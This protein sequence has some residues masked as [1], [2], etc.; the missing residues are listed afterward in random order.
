MSYN[1]IQLRGDFERYEG[2]VAA[3]KTITPGMLVEVSATGVAPVGS[4]KVVEKAFAVEDA[5]QGKPIFSAAE[6]A[7]REASHGTKEVSGDYAAGDLIQYNIQQPGNR[8]YAWVV[9]T[10]TE[11]LAVGQLLGPSTT[12]GVLGKNDTAG[13]T[14]AVIT[15]AVDVTTTPSRVPVRII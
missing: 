4:A 1:S 6:A 3:T 9:G 14:I 8:V 11:T 10:G 2:L 13:Q 5:L 12:E 7:A 15:E